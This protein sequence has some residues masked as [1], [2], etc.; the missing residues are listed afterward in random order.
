MTDSIIMER[1]ADAAAECFYAELVKTED[2]GAFEALV[3]ADARSI[4]AGVLRRCIERF[5]AALADNMP[6]GWSVREHAARTLVTLVGE[7]AFVRT[8]FRDE[9]GAGGAPADELLGIPPRARVS[10]RCF[11]WIAMHASE[12]PLGKTAAEFEALASARISHVTVT[13]VVRREGRLLR[14]RR[15][16]RPRRHADK[17][18]RAVRRVR[19]ALGAPAGAGAREGRAAAL[20]L[21]AGAQDQV[22]RGPRRPRLCGRMPETSGRGWEPPHRAQPLG[23]SVMIPLS[24]RS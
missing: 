18:G 12:L 22:L 20:P 6:G 7:I 21:R 13:N 11:L 23:K 16:V 4:A 15:R 3:A 19:R 9:L 10:P 1:V 24:Q 17:P 8:V 14:G 5:D 2:L